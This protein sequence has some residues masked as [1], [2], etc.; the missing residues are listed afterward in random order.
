[1]PL[2]RGSSLVRA[3]FPFIGLGI[4]LGALGVIA[5]LA[6]LTEETPAPLRI[7][8]A[9]ASFVAGIIAEQVLGRVLLEPRRRRRAEEA[10][11]RLGTQNVLTLLSP[12]LAID[13]DL[14]LIGRSADF[15]SLYAWCLAE[16]ASALPDGRGRSRYRLLTG[17]GGI[18]KTRLALELVDRVETQ[19]WM[20]FFLNPA[21]IND[22]D[23]LATILDAADGRPIL[24]V[25]DD[26]ASFA[27][28][29]RL[30]TRA[31]DMPGRTRLLLLSRSAGGWWTDLTKTPGGLG[32]EL[33]YAYSGGDLPDVT[34]AD[35]SAYLAAATA[36]FAHRL[37][38]RAPQTLAA[39]AG[40][41]MVDVAY[42]ALD[43]VLNSLGPTS[44]AG[45]RV[46]TRSDVSPAVVRAELLRHE[47]RHSWA[48]TARDAGL[49]G[50]LTHELQ[51]VLVAAVALLGAPTRAAAQDV[52]AQ[53]L[54]QPV[55]DRLPTAV[56][57]PPSATVAA[58]WLHATYPDPGVWVAPLTPTAVADQL[59]RK[60]LTDQAGP[61]TETRD[62]HAI[63]LLR[64]LSLDQGIHAIT[65]LLRLAW[66]SVY[67]A[68][69]DTLR[70][71]AEGIVHDLMCERHDPW[72]DEPAIL[73]KVLATLPSGPGPFSEL[74]VTLARQR[75]AA[76]PI[77]AVEARADAADAVFRRL[78]AL[79]RVDDALAALTGHVASVRSLAAQDPEGYESH[80]A[81]TLHVLGVQIDE[82]GRPVEALAATK[83]ATTV[84]RSLAERLPDRHR[85]DLAR[86]LHN[87]GAQLDEVGRPV[88]ALA[89]VEEATAV[90]RSAAERL[91]DC[92]GP[93]LARTLD[94]LG[95]RLGAVGRP[96]EALA[97]A[98][99]AVALYRPLAERLPDCR[100]PD[101]AR[102]L[103]NLGILLG[104][105]GR[106][107]EAL[108]AVEEATTIWRSVAECL[109][110][111]HRPDL[112]QSLYILGIQFGVVGRPVEALAAAEEA[113]ALYRPL[114]EH[115]PDRYRPDLAQTLDCLG[116]QLGDVGRPVDAVAAA[117]EA[118]ALYRPLVERLP[119][120]YRPD[121]ARTLYIL[122]VQLGAVGRLVEAL[123]AAE[124]VVTIYR[125]LAER[126]PDRYR[127]DLA[128]SLH[129]LGIRHHVLD[130]RTNAINAVREALA[131]Y[132]RIPQP[133]M[134]PYAKDK[135]AAAG[136]LIR[137]ESE[138]R[139]Q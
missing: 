49:T 75:W 93:D 98:E 27:D 89:A 34:P 97:A 137:L 94:N 121:L 77:D 58:A 95:V 132:S 28:L 76:L 61:R 133:N 84:W 64:H 134:A 5:V 30:L 40:W 118:V 29:E 82:V 138:G 87:L 60:I 96:V 135:E 26:A 11:R 15:T 99:E 136:F 71:L 110:D 68:H 55:L 18:G 14:P 127:P 31:F 83:E 131:L 13:L 39:P 20:A 47:A 24:I 101:L 111:R 126:L 85:P 7:A 73:E 32:A 120:R 56:V 114:A 38:V 36:A 12:H 123:T 37:G 112:A 90:W 51:E 41:R 72:I 122:G 57:N 35:A 17:P 124:E 44:R 62:Q 129:N 130:R 70:R 52:A 19:G 92:H 16:G 139:T 63:A 1:M 42:L 21:K 79:N 67:Q 54:A 22:N 106:R 9:L 25:L 45:R 48:P 50:S 69:Q 2:G 128:H 74:G 53:V 113:V 115:L 8:A 116:M 88:E 100:R 104:D 108:A 105:V 107:L 86:T 103:D 43:T 59:I 4:G 125:P 117:E 6:L 81:R 23:P 3:M 91:P 46:A 65:V 33:E 78:T 119:D 109:P 66:D 10:V 102:T 80:L